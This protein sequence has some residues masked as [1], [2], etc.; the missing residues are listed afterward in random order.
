MVIESTQILEV[1][2]RGNNIHIH[3][4]VHV[5]RNDDLFVAKPLVKDLNSLCI[6]GRGECESSNSIKGSMIK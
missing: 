2:I 1:T 3:E 6:V 5:L 4:S